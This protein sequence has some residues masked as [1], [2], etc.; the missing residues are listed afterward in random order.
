LR[1]F[2][3]YSAYQALFFGGGVALSVGGVYVLSQRATARP[4]PP[5][6]KD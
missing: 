4:N 5:P 2:Y 1:E 6:A 3:C